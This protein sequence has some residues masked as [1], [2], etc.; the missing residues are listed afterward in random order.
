VNKDDIF[1]VIIILLLTITVAIYS[2]CENFID[3]NLVILI[4]TLILSI[5]WISNLIYDIFCEFNK[6]EN[7]LGI[8]DVTFLL[9][10]VALGLLFSNLVLKDEYVIE[11]FYTWLIILFISFLFLGILGCILTSTI[12]KERRINKIII[13]VII[14]IFIIVFV[15]IPFFSMGIEFWK[16]YGKY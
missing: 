10:I 15:V 6:K 5:T 16:K 13:N 4:L 2:I 7:I 9:F 11:K 14:I 12:L 1:I 8:F 3:K